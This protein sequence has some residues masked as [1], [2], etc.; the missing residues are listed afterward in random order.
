V[1]STQLLIRLRDELGRRFKCN[2]SVRQRGKY[3]QRLLEDALP[4][5][6]GGDDDPL[7]QAALAVE[8]DHDWRPKWPSG[9]SPGSMMGSVT[10]PP[11]RSAV[12]RWVLCRPPVGLRFDA[13]I[14][15]G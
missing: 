13:A 2:V 7:Y 10:P 9:K 5:A 15:G 3:I 11:R 1:A 12:E 4:L 14:F 6:D 8:Q